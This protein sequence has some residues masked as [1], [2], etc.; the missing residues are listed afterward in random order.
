M[1]CD[2]VLRA[3]RRK[4]PAAERRIRPV[5]GAKRETRPECLII[6]TAVR[7]GEMSRGHLRA[8]LPAVLPCN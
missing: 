6:A 2:A 4:A 1:Q 3:R 8:R 7:V 5:R